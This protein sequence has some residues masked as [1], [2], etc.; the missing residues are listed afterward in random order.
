MKQTEGGRCISQLVLQYVA[1]TT[2]GSLVSWAF[3]GRRRLT[4]EMRRVSACA[5]IESE[6]RALSRRSASGK[7]N[8][9]TDPVPQFHHRGKGG[10]SRATGDRTGGSRRRDTFFRQRKKRSSPRRWLSRVSL[11][12]RSTTLP[13]RTSTASHENRDA[14]GYPYGYQPRSGGWQCGLVVS[15]ETERTVGRRLTAR[16]LALVGR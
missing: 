9:E 3:G 10:E 1:D 5:A 16:G 11:N 2:T 15:R 8:G 7:E 13:R 6:R 14:R 4:T 12:A